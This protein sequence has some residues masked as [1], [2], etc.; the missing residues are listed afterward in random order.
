MSAE[1]VLGNAKVAKT[2]REWT[3]GKLRSGSAKGPKVKKRKQ[4][5]AIALSQAGK[6]RATTNASG[7]TLT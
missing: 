7:N 4:A 6:S 1:S 5:V 3:S 2:M